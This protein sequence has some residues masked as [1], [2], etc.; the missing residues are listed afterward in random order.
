MWGFTLTSCADL[1][2]IITPS[3]PQQNSTYNV[4]RSTLTVMKK[5]F[6]FGLQVMKK[7]TA[8]EVEKSPWHLLF[9]ESNFFEEYDKYSQVLFDKMK[10]LANSR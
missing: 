7:I 9:Q 3:Y 10:N 1:M 2:P 4:T 5:E 6:K 8:T